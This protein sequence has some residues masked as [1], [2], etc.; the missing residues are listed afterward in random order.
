MLHGHLRQQ[1]LCGLFLALSV[2]FLAYSLCVY[3]H[4]E[5][6]QLYVPICTNWQGDIEKW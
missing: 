1:N 4:T 5:I 2:D 6:C 3:T